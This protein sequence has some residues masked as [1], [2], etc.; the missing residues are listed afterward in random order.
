[1][2]NDA[3]PLGEHR[4]AREDELQQHKVNDVLLV[5]RNTKV[6]PAKEVYLQ[7]IKWRLVLVCDAEEADL[8][9]VHGVVLVHVREERV[10][11]LEGGDDLCERRF[12]RGGKARSGN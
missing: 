3:S 7:K 12:R 4:T 8:E 9:V 11:R 1:M 2:S 5:L 10:E 6:R